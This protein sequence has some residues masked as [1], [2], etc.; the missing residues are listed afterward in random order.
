MSMLSHE[1]S[2]RPPTGRKKTIRSSMVEVDKDI[3]DRLLSSAATSMFD[4]DEDHTFKHSELVLNPNFNEADTDTENHS[5]IPISVPSL[6]N[7]EVSS[8]NESVPKFHKRVTF[9]ESLIHGSSCGYSSKD[10][11]LNEN[12]SERVK[13][14][15]EDGTN[16]W[17]DITY[18]RFRNEPFSE[19]FPDPEDLNTICQNLGV[20]DTDNDSILIANNRSPGT[21]LGDSSYSDIAVDDQWDY[22]PADSSTKDHSKEIF[23]NTD[24]ALSDSESVSF[25]EEFLRFTAFLRQAHK[26]RASEMI[27]LLGVRMIKQSE[28]VKSDYLDS[29]DTDELETQVMAKVRLFVFHNNMSR[30]MHE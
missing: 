28:D 19:F 22:I 29:I 25:D 1:K 8:A 17:D 24:D 16:E 4:D 14:N 27:Q 20:P 10:S 30:N 18:S 15:S 3:F 11:G 13:G 12:D 26:R 7:Q 6:P 5:Q 2:G 9:A 21:C 23:S